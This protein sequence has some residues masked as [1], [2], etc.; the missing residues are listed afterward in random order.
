MPWVMV[1]SQPIRAVLQLQGDS[2]LAGLV[3]IGRPVA[4]GG[5]LT[6]SSV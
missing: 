5:R 2:F 4:E 3:V 6:A 1:V